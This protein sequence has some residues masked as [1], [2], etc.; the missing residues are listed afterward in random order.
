MASD[1]STNGMHTIQRQLGELHLAGSSKITWRS[2]STQDEGGLQA[3]CMDQLD[4]FRISLYLSLIPKPLIPSHLFT[5]D[6][7]SGHIELRKPTDHT[8]QFLRQLEAL[9]QAVDFAEDLAL[10]SIS[11]AV[12]SRQDRFGGEKE[13]TTLDLED[14]IS[15]VSSHAS[16]P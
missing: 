4:T 5:I 14:A 9:W 6:V 3:P 16:T 2:S 1:P 15:R 7:Q 13:L 8:I 12:T 11:E 10:E